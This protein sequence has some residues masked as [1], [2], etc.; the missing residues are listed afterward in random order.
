VFDLGLIFGPP[1]RFFRAF[2]EEFDPAGGIRVAI[3]L[4]MQLRNMPEA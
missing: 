3:Q 2:Y 1:T 4:E